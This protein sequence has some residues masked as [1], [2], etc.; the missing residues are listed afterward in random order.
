MSNAFGSTL[1]P[2]LHPHV[3]PA[4]RNAYIAFF[5]ATYRACLHTESTNGSLWSS[6]SYQRRLKTLRSQRPVDEDS[7]AFPSVLYP[8]IKEPAAVMTRVTVG[9]K[10][11]SELAS[12]TR[13]DHRLIHPRMTFP[14]FKRKYNYIEPG[15]SCQ[16]PD[17]ITLYGTSHYSLFR[18]TVSC[19]Y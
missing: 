8:R 16:D 1:R 3:Q 13:S 12:T 17:P 19:I 4:H 11:P 6:S 14:A 9:F 18:L 15:A 2:Y 10:R 7:E 5:N